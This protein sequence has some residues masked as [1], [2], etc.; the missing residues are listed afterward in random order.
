M[1]VGIIGHKGLVAQRHIE[2]WEQ[3]GME[4]EGAD[5][6]DDWRALVRAC[7]IVDI[8][9]PIYQ[10]PNMMIYA[11]K[12]KKPVIC[13][14]PIAHNMKEAEDVVSWAEDAEHP[15]C[16]IYQFRYN[17]KVLK[18]KREIDE[19]KYGDIKLV[20]VNY[21]RNKKDYYDKTPWRGCRERAGGGVVLNVTIHYLDLMQWMFGY[22]TRLYGATTT[23]IPGVDIEDVA[24][25]VMQFPSGAVGT[26][27]VMSGAEPQ[28][29]MEFI[30]YGTR[31]GTTI[32]LRH[33]EYH[34]ANFEAFLNG[35]EYVTPIE[36]LKSLR[37]AL[38]ING[39]G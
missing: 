5:R 15:V 25:A 1:K 19:G 9:T 3:M 8:C 17:P 29:H 30:V 21:Y 16:I 31:G 36:A 4:W 35:G 2:A 22:P 26:Y 34:R 24:G 39:R 14:K 10:H 6:N 12:Q 37:M 18:L 27:T 23:S 38:R 11:I 33:N 13:E 32:Q 20:Q 7:D 28:K